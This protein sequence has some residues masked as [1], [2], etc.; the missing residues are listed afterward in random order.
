MSSTPVMGG[1]VPS[2]LFAEVGRTRAPLGTVDPS[3][4][5]AGAESTPRPC[6]EGGGGEPRN[7]TERMRNAD[8]NQL[9]QLTEHLL[10]QPNYTC[11]LDSICTECTPGQICQ[12]GKKQKRIS[13]FN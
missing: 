11:T 2:P 6:A 7:T 5:A 9:S 1:S 13:I 4:A 8:H 3:T 10:K 12:G